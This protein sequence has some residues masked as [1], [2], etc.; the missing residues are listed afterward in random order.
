MLDYFSNPNGIP[1]HDAQI[2]VLAI[3]CKVSSF[4]E[5]AGPISAWVAG[6]MI[7]ATVFKNFYSLTPAK[8]LVSLLL[9]IYSS[10][11][12]V[13][14]KDWIFWKEFFIAGGR[15]YWKWSDRL[16]TQALGEH[17]KP[18]QNVWCD[19]QSHRLILFCSILGLLPYLASNDHSA[20]SRRLIIR[21]KR[22][23]LE[24]LHQCQYD[25]RALLR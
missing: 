22:W 3:Y 1:L 21:E 7:Y 12:L 8:L 14:Q 20:G 9:I 15:E 13:I 11:C 4:H 19:E 6:T 2:W 25:W 16:L 23:R 18:A 5:I 10:R 24:T 17:G